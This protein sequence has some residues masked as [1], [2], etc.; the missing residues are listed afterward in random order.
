MGWVGA[1]SFLKTNG[2]TKKES[3]TL[4]LALLTSFGSSVFLHL[5]YGIFG[6]RGIED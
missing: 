4:K 1:W 2:L 5:S 6:P 3:R